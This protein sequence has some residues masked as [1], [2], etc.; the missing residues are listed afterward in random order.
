MLLAVPVVIFAA[1]TLAESAL[2]LS[3]RFGT[4]F[5]RF[6]AVVV[7][8]ISLGLSPWL[9]RDINSNRQ[10]IHEA[11]RFV[12]KARRDRDP[13]IISQ[14]GWTPFYA[15]LLSWSTC[16]H[17]TGLA[18]SPDVP[19]AD[20]AS[21]DTRE[22]VPPVVHHRPSGADFQVTEVARFTDPRSNRG[23]VIYRVAP[24]ARS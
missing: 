19:T 12:A 13:N 1:G 11:A 18:D 15:G 6:D 14:H 17:A 23:E 2:L 22:V 8:I 3:H 20:M 10:Y 21:F 16:P 4:A 24:A 5:R 7:A 9:V